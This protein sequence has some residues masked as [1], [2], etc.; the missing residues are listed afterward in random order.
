MAD[1]GLEGSLVSSRRVGGGRCRVAK[2]SLRARRL[3]LQHRSGLLFSPLEALLASA[4]R[5]FSACRALE[6]SMPPQKMPLADAWEDDWERI[7]DVRLP[8][9]SKATH[10][11][12]E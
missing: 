2:G 3:P 5:L 7:V 4:N 1:P 11:H 9:Q 8:L 10:A 12:T 6:D